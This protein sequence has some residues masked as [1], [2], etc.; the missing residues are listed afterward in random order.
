M[1][2][3]IGK[4]VAYNV[5]QARLLLESKTSPSIILRKFTF[6]LLVCDTPTR[7]CIVSLYF[8]TTS[9]LCI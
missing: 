2:W 6:D 1:S 7:R 9:S 5:S 3:S 4:M 8:K